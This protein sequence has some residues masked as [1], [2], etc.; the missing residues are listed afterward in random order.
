MYFGN[1]SF[2]PGDAVHF[3][4]A[5]PHNST[6]NI[7]SNVFQTTIKIANFS[8]K[9]ELIEQ[10]KKNWKLNVEQNLWMVDYMPISPQ[11]ISKIFIY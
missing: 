11:M 3:N 10:N 5:P 6:K 7:A 2:D 8:L 9:T 1:L 4:T